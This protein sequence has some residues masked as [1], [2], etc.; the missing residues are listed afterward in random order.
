M[1]HLILQS[2]AVMKLLFKFFAENQCGLSGPLEYD[3]TVYDTDLRI[4]NPPTA[5]V[6]QT[7]DPFTVKYIPG[8][9][10]T[11]LLLAVV[12]FLFKMTL[13]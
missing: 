6:N 2:Q 8:S 11:G 4:F 13:L 7:T 5:C 3:Y 9:I 12:L 10:Y 1:K